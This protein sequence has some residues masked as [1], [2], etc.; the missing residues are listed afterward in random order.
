M[1]I[2]ELYTVADLGTRIKEFDEVTDEAQRAT[3]VLFITNLHNTLNEGGVWGW[4]AAGEIY[5]KKGDG[6]KRIL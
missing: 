2:N 1:M 6:W 4:P 3:N 5:K